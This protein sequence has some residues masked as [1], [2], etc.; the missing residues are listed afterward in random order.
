MEIILLSVALISFFL[1]CFYS[2]GLR[3]PSSAP[4]VWKAGEGWY[5]RS[6]A[7][8]GIIPQLLGQISCL[9]HKENFHH[10]PHLHTGM[11]GSLYFLW[12][13]KTQEPIAW[14]TEEGKRESFSINCFPFN[15]AST[16]TKHIVTSSF[17]IQI[18]KCLQFALKVGDLPWQLLLVLSVLFVLL[19]YLSN[20]TNIYPHASRNIPGQCN[21]GLSKPNK[22]EHKEIFLPGSCLWFLLL[23]TLKNSPCCPKFFSA[24]Q[25]TDIWVK[26]QFVGKDLI[27]S[28]AQFAHIQCYRFSVFL[29]FASVLV[30]WGSFAPLLWELLSRSKFEGSW[31]ILQ[32]CC[33]PMDRQLYT[34]TCTMIINWWISSCSCLCLLK[35]ISCVPLVCAKD[36]FGNV[37]CPVVDSQIQR[38]VFGYD[39]KRIHWV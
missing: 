31:P 32:A 19:Q 39:L 36:V 37:K 17:E 15:W 23:A 7:A 21:F 12:A 2:R 10:S 4:S 30:F 26:I 18:M 27:K 28:I 24:Q 11:F 38:T 29:I 25:Y 13:L 20:E 3:V 34:L 6:Q 5:S 33:L 16:K 14:K 9:I 1:N 35:N 22:V 8:V